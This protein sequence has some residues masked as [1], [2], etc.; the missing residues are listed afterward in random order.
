[1]HG[2]Q[3]WRPEGTATIAWPEKTLPCEVFNSTGTLLSLRNRGGA[4]EPPGAD[5]VRRSHLELGFPGE[6]IYFCTAQTRAD[7]FLP[8][9]TSMQS[10]NRVWGAFPLPES[11]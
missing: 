11:R 10:T 1:M 5:C 7:I 4:E 2:I 9:F 6:R 3:S 8:V